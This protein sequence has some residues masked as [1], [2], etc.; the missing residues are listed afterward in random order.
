MVLLEYGQQGTASFCPH[1][2]RRFPAVAVLLC[3]LAPSAQRWTGGL[4]TPMRVSWEG[5]SAVCHTRATT[6]HRDPCGKTVADMRRDADTRLGDSSLPHG[7]RRVA[8][9]ARRADSDFA[10][11]DSSDARAL[12]VSGRFSPMWRRGGERRH[13]ELRATTWSVHYW[14]V[15]RLRLRRHGGVLRGPSSHRYRDPPGLQ[16]SCPATRS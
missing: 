13:Q 5:L 15:E 6:V 10:L 7:V 12:S 11:L 4:V 2:S 1:T 3:A 14:D 8:M 16:D 9:A